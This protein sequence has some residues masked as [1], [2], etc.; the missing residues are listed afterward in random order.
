MSEIKK[1]VLSIV[2]LYVLSTIV[3]LGILF[4]NWYFGEITALKSQSFLVAQKLSK[5]VFRVLQKEGKYARYV[6][7]KEAQKALLQSI[8]FDMGR[9]IMVFDEKGSVVFNNTRFSP[10]MIPNQEGIFIIGHHLVLNSYGSPDFLTRESRSKSLNQK[11]K[12]GAFR[13]V[14]DGG[15]IDRFLWQLSL[16]VWGLFVVLIVSVGCVSFF[17]VRLSLR[18]LGQKIKE[19]NRFIKDTT[20]EINTPLSIL[21]MSVERLNASKIPEGE[22]KKLHYIQAASKTLENIYHSLVYT[23][24]GNL[25]REIKTI[26]MQELLMERLDFFSFYF[27][28]K[29]FEIIPHLSQIFLLADSKAMTLVIDN[30]LSNAI[31]YTPKNG[32]I[33]VILEQEEKDF[34]LRVRDNGI[35]IQEDHLKR[36]FDR[37]ERFDSSSG[38][39][40]LGLNIV[41]KIC[42]EFHIEIDVQSEYGKGSEFVLRWKNEE[43]NSMI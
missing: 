7:T 22:R 8:A 29:H 20:H 32:K 17:L 19:L 31:K 13:I 40:G 43:L 30:L 26:D 10:F 33:E 9:Q 6:K 35:G 27:E 2:L 36:I 16:K 14:I 24:F 39:F 15:N 34:V 1:T 18:P 23:S 37:Y 42:D 12:N 4:G 5:R 38:G 21:Q 28:Q 25:E 11:W 3:F 41:K